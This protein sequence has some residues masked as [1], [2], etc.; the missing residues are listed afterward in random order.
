MKKPGALAGFFRQCTCTCATAYPAKYRLS[1]RRAR[2][3][4]PAAARALVNTVAVYVAVDMGAPDDKVGIMPVISP[5]CNIHC[6]CSAPQ[7]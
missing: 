3:V 7:H 5:H 6:R 1:G 2:D 4:M